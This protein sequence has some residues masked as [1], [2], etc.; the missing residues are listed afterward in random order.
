WFCPD[1]IGIPIELHPFISFLPE[2]S[3][4]G[5]VPILSGY[6]LSYTRLFHSHL[7]ALPMVLSRISRDTN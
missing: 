5:F 3:A 1:S 7:N 2:R 6:Q 4:N